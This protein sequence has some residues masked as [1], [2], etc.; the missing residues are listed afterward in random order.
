MG[1]LL[2]RSMLRHIRL[3]IHFFFMLGFMHHDSG[4]SGL[5]S[6]C[7]QEDAGFHRLLFPCKGSPLR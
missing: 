1:S 2:N 3:L 5:V 7:I 4:F 6:A